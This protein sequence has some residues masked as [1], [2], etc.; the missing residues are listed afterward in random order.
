M[1]ATHPK[2]IVCLL[3][4]IS[5]GAQHVRRCQWLLTDGAREPAGQDE[6]GQ[7]RPQAPLPPL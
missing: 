4:W 5:A 6:L 3:L 1:Q 7:E 2:Q